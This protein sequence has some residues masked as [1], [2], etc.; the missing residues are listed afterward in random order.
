ML[1]YINCI[2]MCRWTGY[3][4]GAFSSGTGLTH[5]F[6]FGSQVTKAVFAIHLTAGQRWQKPSLTLVKDSTPL[7]LVKGETKVLPNLTLTG[8]KILSTTVKDVTSF[9]ARQSFKSKA[10][11]KVLFT[12]DHCVNDS[13]PSLSHL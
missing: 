7:T 2:G 8:S 6:D 4:L 1:P 9:D 13:R 12:F 11:S 3:G 10:I 5:T